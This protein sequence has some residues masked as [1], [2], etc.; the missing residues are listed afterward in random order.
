MVLAVEMSCIFAVY[1]AFCWGEKA[2]ID[3]VEP[4]EILCVIGCEDMLVGSSKDCD[5]T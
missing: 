1:G 3:V 5:Y 2:F 4:A